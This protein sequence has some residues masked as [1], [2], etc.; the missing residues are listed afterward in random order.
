[1]T[2]TK[3]GQ[4][5][6]GQP[7]EAVDPASA[8][9]GVPLEWHK[10]PAS[11]GS[12]TAETASDGTPQWYDGDR[13]IILIE[14]N[15]GQEIAVVDIDCDEHYFSAKDASSGDEYDA[16]GPESWSWWAKLTPRHLP[17]NASDHPTAS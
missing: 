11:G 14:T 2:P 10:G 17:P 3:P 13:L 9:L 12:G 16:W 1:M 8:L 6:Y 5:N 4:A 7:A 15:H